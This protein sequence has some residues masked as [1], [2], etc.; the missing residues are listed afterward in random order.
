MKN[1]KLR[2]GLRFWLCT[3]RHVKALAKKKGLIDV[4]LNTNANLLT[5][6]LGKALLDAG[7]DRISFSVDGYRKEQYAKHRPGGNF[8]KVRYN[9]MN[10]LSHRDDRDYDCGIRI[11]TVDLPDI[12][13]DKFCGVA[14]DRASQPH[15]S[16][17]LVK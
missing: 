13:F 8:G 6:R 7:L 9:I 14:F 1:R 16:T 3:S 11:Q 15:S 5:D 17:T 4:Y 2:K 12:D 10:F